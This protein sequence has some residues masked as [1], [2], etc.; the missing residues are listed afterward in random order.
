MVTYLCVVGLSFQVDCF[1]CCMLLYTLIN[2]RFRRAVDAVL[3]GDEDV[4]IYGRDKS[5]ILRR[6]ENAK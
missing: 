1:Y 5:L 2:Q 6:K 4:G 3:R